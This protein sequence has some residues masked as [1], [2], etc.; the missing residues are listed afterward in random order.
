VD[1]TSYVF[2]FPNDSRSVSNIINQLLHLSIYALIKF[3]EASMAC[4]AIGMKL[5]SLYQ[6]F[7]YKNI[8]A[9]LKSKAISNA[10]NL[11]SLLKDSSATPSIF[12]TS[13]TD[14]GCEGSFG[15]CSTSRLVRKEAM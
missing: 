9:A 10:P 4:C 15:Y 6:D 11:L 2:S 8:E 14:E 1:H 12:W 3:V 13:A 5:L 7:K